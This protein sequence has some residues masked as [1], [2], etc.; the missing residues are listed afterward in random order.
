MNTQPRPDM[1]LW[2]DIII[3]LL[4]TRTLLRTL[5]IFFWKVHL[6]PFVLFISLSLG[7]RLRLHILDSC[8]LLITS[9]SLPIKI[10]FD[11]LKYLRLS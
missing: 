3:N 8:Q 4:E 6:S 7:K 11:F 10:I 9:D 2:V 1:P 5:E